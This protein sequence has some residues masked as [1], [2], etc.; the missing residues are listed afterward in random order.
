MPVGDGRTEPDPSPPEVARMGT[1]LQHYTSHFGRPSEILMCE[2]DGDFHIDTYTY[3][4]T[5]DRPYVTLATVGMSAREMNNPE[6]VADLNQIELIMYLERDW[7][8]DSPIGSA[9]IKLLH[10]SARYP[11]EHDTW[12]SYGH[13]IAP[14]DRPQV[15]GSLLTGTYFRPPPEEKGFEHLDLPDG[16]ACHFLWEIPITDAELYV[17]VTEGANALDNYLIEARYLELDVDRACF[18]SNEN[19]RQRRARKRAQSNRARLPRARTVR[20]LRC[21]DPTCGHT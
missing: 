20:Q 8:F 6:E 19:R 11:F 10:S 4:A 12:L 5:V 21:Q 1:L 17:K 2:R 13:S 15:P 16:T 9:P 14:G 3:D 7:D 18:V